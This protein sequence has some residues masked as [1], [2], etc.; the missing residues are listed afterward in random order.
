[1]ARK[2]SLGKITKGELHHAMDEAERAVRKNCRELSS[3]VEASSCVVGGMIA[4]GAAAKQLGKEAVMEGKLGIIVSPVED[5]PKGFEAQTVKGGRNGR[6]KICRLA[7]GYRKYRP[8]Q[9][10]H[11]KPMR[12]K[13]GFKA[14]VIK[15]DIRKAD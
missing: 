1:M 7:D 15:R 5:C 14:G 13:R 8:D 2:S 11:G 3:D 12:R 10:P 6:V 9:R 4:I